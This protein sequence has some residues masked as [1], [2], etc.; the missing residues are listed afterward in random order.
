VL[1]GVLLAERPPHVLCPVAVFLHE[2][3][4]RSLVTLSRAAVVEKRHIS[5]TMLSAPGRG[6]VV[7]STSSP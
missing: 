3:L 7:L 2:L 4:Q 6:V 1:S 5:G